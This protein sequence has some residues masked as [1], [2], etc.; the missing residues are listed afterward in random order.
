MLKKVPHIV[1]DPLTEFSRKAIT[2]I[3]SVPEGCVATYGQIARLAG[4]PR[5]SRRV[6][7]LLHSGTHKYALP[8]QRI[9]KS[10]GRLPFPEDSPIFLMQ[11][12]QLEAEGVVVRKGRVDLKRFLWKSHSGWFFSDL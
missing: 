12:N 6:G 2:L 11:K 10:D 7:W 9:I 8:W 1:N 5:G 3:Q 4:N